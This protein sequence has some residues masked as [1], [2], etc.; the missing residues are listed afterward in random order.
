MIDHDRLFKELISTFFWEFLELFTPKV[1]EYIEKDSLVFLPEEVLTDV[2]SGEKRRIDLL[3]KVKFQGKDTC[4]L[5]HLENQAYYQP[6]FNRRMFNYFARLQ[7]KYQLP[8][9]PV[10]VFSYD[11]PL[12]IEPNQYKIVFPDLKVLEFNYIT[13]ELQHFA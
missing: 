10:V 11:K 8:I 3:A 5:I 4:F 6:E 1:L 2:T 12:T 9:Y 13:I 7:E